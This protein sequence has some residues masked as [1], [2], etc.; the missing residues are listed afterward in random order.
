MKVPE[1]KPEVALIGENGSAFAILGKVTHVLQDAGADKEY[2]ES[3]Y[4]KATAGDYG[5]LLQVTR[6]F[7]DIT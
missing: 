2:I 3:Y 5:N 4:N 1:N 7:V 6:E